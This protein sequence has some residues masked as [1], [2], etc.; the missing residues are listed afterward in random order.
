MTARAGPGGWSVWP[1]SA[2]PGRRPPGRWPPA[3]RRSPCWTPATTRYAAPGGR[4]RQAGR[5]GSAR[6]RGRRRRRAAG[7]PAGGHLAGLAPGRAAAGRGGRRRDPGHRRRRAGLAAAPGARRRHGAGLAGRH[8]HQRQ[9]DHGADARRHAGGGRAAFGRGGERRH[10]GGRG[11]DRGAA[12]RRAGRRAVQLPAALEF[13]AASV[14]ATVLNVAADHIDWHGDLESYARDKGRIFA[15]GTI[16]VCNAEDGWS[17][18]LVAEAPGLSRVVPFRLGPPARRRVRRV[19]RR[20]GRPRVRRATVLRPGHRRAA[21]RAAQRGQR[22][23]RGGS[24]PRLW[25]GARRR[26]CRAARLPARTAPDHRVAEVGGVPYVDDSK[27]TNPHAAAASL[28][29][30]PSVVWVA[31]GMLRG[32]AAD[33]DDLVRGV[34][35]RL[36]GGSAARPRPRHRGAGS[37]ATRAGCP[38]C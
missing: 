8:R 5:Q 9:D 17:R 1:A 24:G 25:G 26:P 2:S 33:I 7:H 29:A 31:G 28:A 35:G 12:L 15:P 16:A 14:A 34:A 11:G 18:R 4:A 19:R 23:C 10:L 27:A 38:R 3:A 37:R 22:A 30:Y 21:R 6:P 32:E 36:R 13:L 20:P